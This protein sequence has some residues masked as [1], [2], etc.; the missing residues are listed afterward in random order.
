MFYS[1]ILVVFTTR[2]RTFLNDE[3]NEGWADEPKENSEF[4]FLINN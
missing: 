4:H 3:T 2:R 1:I